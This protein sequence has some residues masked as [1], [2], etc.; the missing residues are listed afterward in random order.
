MEQLDTASASDRHNLV[1]YLGSM[2]ITFFCFYGFNYLVTWLTIQKTGNPQTLGHVMALMML[3]AIGLNLVAGQVLSHYSAKTIMFVT[4]ILTAL[5]FIGAYGWF[6]IRNWTITGLVVVAILNK[7]IGV[8]YKLGNKTVLPELFASTRLKTI[9]GYQTQIRQLA[10]V[11]ATTIITGALLWL[12]PATLI[13]IMGGAFGFSAGL[14]WQFQVSPSAPSPQ[15]AKHSSFRSVALPKWALSYAVIGY[16]I[17]AVVAV[18]IP[19]IA[20]TYLQGHWQLSW[21]LTANAL[22]ILLGP[23]VFRRS[24]PYTLLTLT[25]SA[26]ICLLFMRASLYQLLPMMLVLGVLRSQTNI[27]FFTHIQQMPTSNR[28]ALMMW[29]L[30]IID[31]STVIGSLLAPRLILHLGSRALPV[32]GAVIVGFC[33]I[34]QAI[35]YHYR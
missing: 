28:H 30:T 13:L 35:D 16:L 23:V 31:T 2:I 15:G 21:L 9:N 12:D 32:L 14:D 34:K 29:V 6:E 1:C 10:I 22:G 24:K 19:W 4:D 3:P 8:F 18:C 33:L 5:L 26:G 20:I 11:S 27:Q 17:D 7:S 25:L